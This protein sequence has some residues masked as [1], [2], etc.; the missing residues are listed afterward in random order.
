MLL[1]PIT[2]I[3]VSAVRTEVHGWSFRSRS[4]LGETQGKVVSYLTS[5]MNLKANV[6]PAHLKRTMEELVNRTHPPVGK[7]VRSVRPENFF[8]RPKFVVSSN[9]AQELLLS[10]PRT[11][12]LAENLHP[13]DAPSLKNAKKFWN[14]FVFRRRSD[15][16]SVLPIRN[17]EV[18]QERCRAIPF[19]QRVA[20]E[21]CEMLVMKNHLCF[22]TC[23][24]VLVSSSQ[25]GRTTVCSHCSPVKFSRKNVQLRCTGDLQVTKAVTIVEDCQCERQRGRHSHYHHNGPVLI[26]P[27]LLGNQA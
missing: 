20:H 4:K 1:V 26:D 19:L 17:N 9:Q 16:Q 21:D 2:F 25:E 5:K 13:T 27:S 3:F 11:T 7:T 6:S 14:H 15:F 24:S 23:S 18:H 12:A 8:S 22:G 10:H